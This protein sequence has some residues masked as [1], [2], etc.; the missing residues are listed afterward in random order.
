M[1]TRRGN[2]K[3]RP[4]TGR[5]AGVPLGRAFLIGPGLAN[6][7]LREAVD[8]VARVH[9][10]GELPTIPIVRDTSLEVRARL[11]VRDGLPSTIA[12]SPGAVVLGIG[13]IHEIGPARCGSV[14]PHLRRSL[15][16]L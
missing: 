1:T 5:P 15:P 6:E 3:N 13:L 14:R 12:A 7:P 8:A 9:G 10:D 4:P 16:L 11:V 2:G